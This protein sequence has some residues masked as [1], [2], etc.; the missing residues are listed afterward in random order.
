[1]LCERKFNRVSDLFE[2]AKQDNPALTSV[3]ESPM[4]G[5]LTLFFSNRG[6]V[7]DT[8]PLVCWRAELAPSCEVH[9]PA[10]R[11]FRMNNRCRCSDDDILEL[12]ATAIKPNDLIKRSAIIFSRS[13]FQ[14]FLL[15]PQWP[16]WVEGRCHGRLE[17]FFRLISSLPVSTHSSAFIDDMEKFKRLF[18]IWRDEPRLGSGAP[19]QDSRRI[20]TAHFCSCTTVTILQ[21]TCS[22]I[23]K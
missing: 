16:S 21:G 13:F 9:R 17:L 14:P 6:S 1:M 12:L 7:A 10:D 20:N 19:G 18:R 3:M 23:G 4:D 11:A 22:T 8:K 5:T 15:V 2:H